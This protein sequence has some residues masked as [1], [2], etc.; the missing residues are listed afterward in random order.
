MKVKIPGNYQT[1]FIIN[2]TKNRQQSNKF[3][4]TLLPAVVI[5]SENGF[6]HFC[7]QKSFCPGSIDENIGLAAI[8]T[9]SYDM[10]VI[11]T[12]HEI[13]M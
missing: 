7:W 6:I 13:H 10:K 2:N 9:D 5:Y 1:F 3:F 12:D 8:F 11:G 4:L